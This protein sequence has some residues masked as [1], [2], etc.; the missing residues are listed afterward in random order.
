L[1]KDQVP[2]F[3]Q[4][5]EKTEQMC[6]RVEVSA[7]KPR[8]SG[9]IPFSSFMRAIA[10]SFYDEPD[11]TLVRLI[12]YSELGLSDLINALLEEEGEVSGMKRL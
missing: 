10:V 3:R 12:S 4:H 5:P 1:I 9:D 11:S 6:A 2:E 7:P 8:A